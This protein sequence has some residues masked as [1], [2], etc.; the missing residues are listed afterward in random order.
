MKKQY[1][2]IIKK[3]RNDCGESI[4][5]VLIAM[6]IIELALLMAVSMI[7]SSGRIITKTEKSYDLYYSRR[8]A[9][10]TN[11]KQG[12]QGPAPIPG[13]ATVTLTISN[14]PGATSAITKAVSTNLYYV[15]DDNNKPLFAT[16]EAKST[17]SGS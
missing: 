7:M 11:E 8:N 12:E 3:L 16:Y 9:I 2:R 4:A 10:E 6:L 5:E 1:D 17:G 15:Q 14:L 13:E